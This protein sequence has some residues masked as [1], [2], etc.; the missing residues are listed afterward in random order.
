[1]SP[2][3]VNP[4]IPDMSEVDPVAKRVSTARISTRGRSRHTGDG[5]SDYAIRNLCAEVLIV[6]IKDMRK[7]N[8]S[9]RRFLEGTNG[10]LLFWAE[11]A[12]VDMDVIQEVLSE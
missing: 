2:F 5:T 1:M 6:A 4:V 12:N 8:T 9:A 11:A 3:S 7:G 10:D